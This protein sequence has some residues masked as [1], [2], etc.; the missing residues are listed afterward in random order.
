MMLNTGLAGIL[1]VDKEENLTS[2]GVVSRVKRALGG[3]RSP[4]VGHA[5]TLDPFATGL[6]VVM[7]GQATKLSPY[8]AGE[9]KIYRAEMKLGE[10]TDTLDLTGRVVKRVEKPYPAEREVKDA[11]KRF[12]GTVE[13]SP[14]MYSAVRHQGVRAYR[15]ARKGIE[16][17][18]RKRRVN[19]YYLDLIEYDPPH[20]TLEIHCS[21]GT[22]IR[23]LAADLGEVLGTAAHLTALRRLTVGRFRLTEAVPSSELSSEAQCL[24]VISGHLTAPVDALHGIPSVSVSE[25]MAARIRNGYQPSMGEMSAAD[26]EICRVVGGLVKVVAGRELVALG[27][28]TA[29]VESKP[30]GLSMERVFS[31]GG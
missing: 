8:L 9:D 11:L 16:V 1:L 22:Y 6:L 27:R 10:A 18:L 2:R 26:E 20:A 31:S 25:G 28:L 3:R 30:A 15:L 21:S 23:T 19:I 24:R 7:V 12:T 14:P 4:K 13:Q 17:S 5:G 29:A